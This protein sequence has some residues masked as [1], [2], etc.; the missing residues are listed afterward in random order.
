MKMSVS[1]SQLLLG[2]YAGTSANI[3]GWKYP[4][5]PIGAKDTGHEF[6][7]LEGIQDEALSQ[8]I[9]KQNSMNEHI[10]N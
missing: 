2:S 3:L 4:M 5:V 8:L 6:D 9:A 7:V 1:P 10:S